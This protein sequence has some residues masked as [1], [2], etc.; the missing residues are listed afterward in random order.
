MQ[1]EKKGFKQIAHAS[2]KEHDMRRGL[3][4]RSRCGVGESCARGSAPRALHF[5]C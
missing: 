4:S 5:A 3:R 1:S 2:D